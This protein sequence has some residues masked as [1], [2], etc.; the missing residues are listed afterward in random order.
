MLRRPPRSTRTVPLFPYTTPFRSVDGLQARR[1]EAWETGDFKKAASLDDELL[2]YKLAAKE[3]AKSGKPSVEVPEFKANDE[4]L[5]PD[6]MDTL[7]SWA[8]EKDAS[9]TPLRPWAK[10][11][12][13]RAWGREG[14]CQC[15]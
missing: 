10:P 9:G 15:V 8:Q 3:R 1:Q 4:P 7:A 5:S 12:I 14:G 2:D 6:H 13:G 11:D